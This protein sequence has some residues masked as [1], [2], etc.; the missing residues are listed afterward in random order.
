[1]F[2]LHP[3][4][5]TDAVNMHKQSLLVAGHRETA[6]QMATLKTVNKL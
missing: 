2:S 4:Y 6:G 1:M 5:I 3:T